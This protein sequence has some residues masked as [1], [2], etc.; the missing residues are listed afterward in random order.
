MI[1][2]YTSKGMLTSLRLDWIALIGAL[3][4]FAALLIVSAAKAGWVFEYPL[5]DPY[6]HLAMSAEISRG[7]YGVN[8]G[9]FASAASSALFPLLLMISPETE[10]QR[11]LPFAWNLVGL[12]LIAILWGRALIWSG[13]SGVLGAL[14]AFFGPLLVGTIS[15]AYVGMEHTLHA[16]ASIAIIFGLARFLSEGRVPWML[17]AGVFF[18]PILRFEG[19]ALVCLAIGVLYLNDRKRTAYFAAALGLL[20]VAAFVIYLLS[21]GLD[22]LPNSVQAKLVSNDDVE[23]SRLRRI[24]ST[25]VINL[26]KSGGQGIAA[27]SFAALLLR[28]LSPQIRQ[29]SWNWLALTILLAGVA[30]LLFG[31][32][33]WMERYEH[34]ALASLGLGVLILAA[35]VE[36]RK[37]IAQGLA[38]GSLFVAGWYYVQESVFEYHWGSRAI[39]NQQAQ[40]SR[41]AKDHLNKNVAVNDLGWVS[42]GNQNYVLDLFGLA[43]DEA[44]ELRIYDNSQGWGGPL[45]K[46]HNVSVIMIYDEMVGEAVAPEW[47]PLG[48]LVMRNPRG[49]LGAEEVLFF[50]ANAD[51]VADA[52]AALAA[53][54]PELPVDTCFV[55]IETGKCAQ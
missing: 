55:L 39:H 45:V 40:M 23:I 9:E 15:T 25:I 54:W 22:P 50:A 38:I 13:Y 37:F 20:P 47:V 36:R 19:L 53:W 34:Y 4:M 2:T 11:L 18:A 6:I 42:W 21:L 43:N 44:R 52:N 7:G 16:A 29:T 27:I 24:Y 33:G 35:Q 49:Y 46:R 51:E 26:T 14:L 17:F 28:S 1:R 5:D 30:H 32:V 12:A 31:Q 10:L 48:K 8:A 3:L 41:F